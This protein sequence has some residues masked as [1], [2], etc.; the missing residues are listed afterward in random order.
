M[1]KQKNVNALQK[2]KTSDKIKWIIAFTLIF[3]ILAGVVAI[4]V[5][6]I[7]SRENAKVPE[8][9]EPVEI[10]SVTRDFA[11]I[12]GMDLSLNLNSYELYYL[13]KKI[14]YDKENFDIF[15]KL[16]FVPEDAHIVITAELSGS[17]QDKGYIASYDKEK[18]VV[19][20]TITPDYGGIDKIRIRD[21]VNDQNLTLILFE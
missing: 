7:T 4:S 20:F 19:T 11:F 8:V 5:Q 10:S 2:H 9:V 12:G 21:T 15:I 18:S 1:K 16:D 3:V 17:A 13:N 14:A 6:M